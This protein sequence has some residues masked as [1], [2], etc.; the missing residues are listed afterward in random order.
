MQ[1]NS[2]AKGVQTR[3]DNR[4]PGNSGAGSSS[5]ANGRPWTREEEDE[6]RELASTQTIPTIAKQLGRTETS[7]RLK[8]KSLRFE[9][10]DLAG[11]KVKDLAALLGRTVR[12]VRRWREKRYLDGVNG[13]IISESFAKFCKNHG[14]KIPYC[15]LDENVNCGF[16]ATGVGRM[17]SR[18]NDAASPQ[19]VAGRLHPSSAC[20]RRKFLV[21]SENSIAPP[22]VAALVRRFGGSVSMQGKSVR[23]SGAAIARGWCAST[24]AAIRNGKGEST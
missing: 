20:S 16:G 21:Q 15:E 12:Q 8:L 23:S 5:W 11:F 2:E 13:R 22:R 1:A 14:E 6:L 17:R 3:H 4:S 10:H 19:G 18:P 9:Y 7:V 24:M